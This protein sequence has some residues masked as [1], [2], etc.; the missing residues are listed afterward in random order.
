[1][2][3]SDLRLGLPFSLFPL[4]FLSKILYAFFVSSTRAKIS[5]IIFFSP[6]Q[7]VEINL[8]ISNIYT[9]F[10]NESNIPCGCYDLEQGFKLFPFY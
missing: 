6:N 5:S 9:H 1:M 8:F 4:E 3:S 7:C 2:L 10:C